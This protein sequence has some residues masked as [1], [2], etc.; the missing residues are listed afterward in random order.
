ML[1]LIGKE[2]KYERN[3]QK[4]R[5]SRGNEKGLPAREQAKMDLK[6][7]KIKVLHSKGLKRGEIRIRRFTKYSKMIFKS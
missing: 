5:E 7:K 4:R 3:N 1:T 6:C 2:E